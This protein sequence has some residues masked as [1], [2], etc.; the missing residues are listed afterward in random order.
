MGRHIIR[1]LHIPASKFITAFC[2]DDT[3]HIYITQA[4]IYIGFYLQTVCFNSC[5]TVIAS[6]GI[7]QLYRI[8]IPLI[9]NRNCNLCV[10][11]KLLLFDIVS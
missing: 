2:R 1:N 8:S 11:C 5:L 6:A 9:G 7:V 4:C 3:V 10:L